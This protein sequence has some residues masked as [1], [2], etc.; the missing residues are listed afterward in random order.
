LK[1]ADIIRAREE[2]VAREWEWLLDAINL[3]AGARSGESEADVF[4]L[5]Q[6]H[7]M[8]IGRRRV[9]LAQELAKPASLMWSF[10]GDHK[11]IMERVERDIAVGVRAHTAITRSESTV[12]VEWDKQ[13]TRVHR[14][15]RRFNEAVASAKMLERLIA[16]REVGQLPCDNLR[17]LLRDAEAKREE[18]RAALER[19]GVQN[20][21]PR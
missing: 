3:V 16:N 10:A 7:A 8:D 15:H 2:E 17:V 4:W 5:L 19:A 21:L 18:A 20:F 9:K 6:H 11:S 14:I 12:M 1:R 13:T